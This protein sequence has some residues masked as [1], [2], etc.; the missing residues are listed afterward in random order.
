[1]SIQWQNQ[2]FSGFVQEPYID[3]HEKIT[4]VFQSKY[5][6]LKVNELKTHS[7]E[8]K[9]IDKAIQRISKTDFNAQDALQIFNATIAGYKKA[10]D[11]LPF[12]S[13]LQD[14]QEL[15]RQLE[16]HS[17]EQLWEA[18]WFDALLDIIDEPQVE[19]MEEKREWFK[20]E[21]NQDLLG[22]ITHLSFK[23]CDI[24]H[25]PKEVFK[26][27]NL[28]KLDLS[29]N[30]I[31]VLPESIKVW[32]RL[33][34]LNLC[35]NDLTYLPHNGVKHLKK[36]K[37][38]NVSANKLTSLPRAIGLLK[39]LKNLNAEEN[40]LEELPKEICRCT[41]LENLNVS[42][43]NL[44]VL[45]EGIKHLAALIKFSAA[46]NELRYSSK[47]LQTL[48]LHNWKQIKKV[49]LS[50]NDLHTTTEFLR[51]LWPNAT[52]IKHSNF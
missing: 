27:R 18:L 2:F 21:K 19:T 30:L 20:D 33:K 45:P 37:N 12:V 34:K 1:M 7:S 41:F 50:Q 9:L 49:D 47:E 16:N 25:L 44:S 46:D 11:P 51:T 48:E 29:L 5:N 14:L 40:Y 23:N 24:V 39:N 17:L 6:Q 4:N 3:F 31:E 26:L 38:L 8:F 28:R 42:S 13:C 43:N 22:K 15:E 52:T 36:I 35:Y 10:I 32:R